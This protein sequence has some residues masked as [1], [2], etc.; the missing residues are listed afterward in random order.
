M[1]PLTVYSTLGDFCFPVHSEAPSS[2]SGEVVKWW[3]DFSPC[4]GIGSDFDVWTFVREDK[5][6]Q[7]SIT[8]VLI[9]IIHTQLLPG[10]YSFTYK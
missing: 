1:T 7:S 5:L 2:G 8:T 3:A 10:F 9:Y 4:L 6:A